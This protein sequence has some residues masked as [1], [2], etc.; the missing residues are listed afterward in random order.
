MSESILVVEDEK[1]LLESLNYFLQR[2]G[3]VVDT[4]ADGQAALDSARK[5]HPDLILLDVML[6]VL[7]G[8][9]VAK[10]LRKEMNTPILMLTARSD[11]IDRVI[12]LEVGADDYMTKPFGLRE[13]EAR[14]KAMLRRVRLIRE[15]VEQ[16]KGV[17]PLTSQPL[18]FGNLSLDEDRHVIQLDGQMLEMNPKEYDLLS[19]FMQHQGKAFSRDQLLKEIW[20]W[21]F[22]GDSRTVDVHVRWLREKIEADPSKPTRLVTVRGTGYRFES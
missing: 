10:I 13:L 12:G 3:F 20:G 19:F 2:E 15:E 7:D 11:E 18:V 4:A 16:Q 9:E 5:N 22:S 17:L 6:P 21:D 8:F 1:A 14:I